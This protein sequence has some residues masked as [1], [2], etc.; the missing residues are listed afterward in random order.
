MIHGVL[1]RTCR[2][3]GNGLVYVFWN[4]KEIRGEVISKAV[5]P[6]TILLDDL[7]PSTF[8]PEEPKLRDS[9]RDDS[10]AV[11]AK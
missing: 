4:G 6:S 8:F 11:A 10:L 7:N 2:P 9:R 3:L 5:V 1:D